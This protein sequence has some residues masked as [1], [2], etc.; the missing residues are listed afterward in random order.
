MKLID[1]SEFYSEQGG[2][3]RTYVNQKLDAS[4]RLGH[5]TVIVAPG[6]RT[7]EDVRI[8]GKIIWVKAPKMPPDPR[9]HMFW[10]AQAVH[11]IIARER[12]D[13]IEGSSPW[14]GGWIAATAP[15]SALKVLI[16]HADPVAVYPHTLFGRFLA[17][18]KIDHL[19]GWFWSYMRKLNARF[20]AT[21]VAGAWLAHRFERFGLKGL[22]VAPFGIDKAIFTPQARSS[23]VR[24]ELLQACGLTPE[25]KV[26][27]TVGRHHPEKRLGTL[28]D[29]VKHVNQARRVGLFVI[30]DGPLRSWVERQASRA[31]HIHLA[32]QIG[33]RNLLASYLASGDALIHGSA[34]ET[35]GLAVAEGLSCGQPIIVPTTGGAAD[36]A[37]PAYSETYTAGNSAAAADAILRLLAR[38]PDGLRL[39]ASTGAQ[40]VGR[41]EAHFERM[42]DIYETLIAGRRLNAATAAP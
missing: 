9:Y 3:V 12:P 2:G 6:A 7:Y 18:H 10:Q 30:G 35:Y 31:P 4:A 33:D 23:T 28:I 13:V 8:G 29:A 37:D 41:V 26:L 40:K 5:E 25:D 1:I 21:L 27:V 17:P 15:T 36:F 38:D 32:G 34:S 16:M 42:F 24:T 22:Q 14:R 20:D 39:A 19:F 11:D